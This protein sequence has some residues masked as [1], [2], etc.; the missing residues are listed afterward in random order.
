MVNML[1]QL[2]NIKRVNKILKNEF[3]ERENHDKKKVFILVF[4]IFQ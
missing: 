4:S 1:K 3:N 2:K